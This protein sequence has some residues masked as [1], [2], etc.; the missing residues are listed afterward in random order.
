MGRNTLGSRYGLK[1]GSNVECDAQE[2]EGGEE[3]CDLVSNEHSISH[4]EDQYG[5]MFHHHLELNLPLYDLRPSLPSIH[6][7]MLSSAFHIF[8]RSHISS[9]LTTT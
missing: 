5:R 6:D 7:S 2:L 4:Y 1:Y 8:I 9:A 3:V